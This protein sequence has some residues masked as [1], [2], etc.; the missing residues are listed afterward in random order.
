[1]VRHLAAFLAA[2]GI[3]MPT[4]AVPNIAE[5]PVIGPAA[6]EAFNQIPSNV[7]RD[8]GWPTPMSSQGLGLNSAAPQQ[9]PQPVNIQPQ[10]QGI[11]NRVNARHGGQVTISVFSPGASATAG[12]NRP[13]PAFSTM[14]VP[15][16][17]AA[18]KQDGPRW[19]RDAE[20][21]VTVSDNPAMHRMANAI[22]THQVQTVLGEGRTHTATSPAHK[23]ST[24]WTTSEQARFAANLPCVNGSGPVVGMMARITPD[25]RWGLGQLPGARFKGGWNHQGG[26]YLAR[27]FGLVRGPRGDVAIAI[28]AYAPHGGHGKAT[29]MLNDIAAE[30]NGQLGSLPVA[31]CG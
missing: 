12:D 14:K 27:Q 17:I 23:M 22:P 31:R 19:Y 10:L 8:L 16:S 20:L 25:Q 26:G 28:T 15:V 24:L 21:A 18:L 13:Q 30:L 3:A 1:M 4:I 11:V 5:M 7:K 6:V 9:R 2:A 29:H